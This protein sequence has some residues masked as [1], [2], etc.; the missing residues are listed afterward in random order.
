MIAT[1]ISVPKGNP[2]SGQLLIRL[3]PELL[4]Q[5]R[6]LAER[7]K[8]SATA[9]VEWIVQRYLESLEEPKGERRGE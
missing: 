2:R 4:T 9:Q 8:R 7:E 1:I 3:S 6:E 5:L